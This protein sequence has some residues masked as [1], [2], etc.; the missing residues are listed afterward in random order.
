MVHALCSVAVPATIKARPA[1]LLSRPQCFGSV[2]FWYGSGST[3]PYLWLTDPDPTPAPDPV[4]FVSGFQDTNKK[5]LFL[6]PNSRSVSGSGRSKKLWIRI[7]NTTGLSARRD[8]GLNY[9]TLFLRKRENSTAPKRENSNNLFYFSCTCGWS[10]SQQHAT[11][12]TAVNKT[13]ATMLLLYNN[14]SDFVC[15][16]RYIIVYV[17]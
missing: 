17:M 2:I 10:D 16:P 3:D 8:A 15:H 11:R 14:K 13:I 9:S 6:P 5:Y 7:R 4:L 12:S 1:P